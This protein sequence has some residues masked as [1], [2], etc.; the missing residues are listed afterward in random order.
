MAEPGAGRAELHLALVLLGVGDEFLE[1]L[2]RQ[3]LAH[4]QQDRN[5]GDERDRREIVDGAVERLLIQRLALGV[6]ADGPEHHGVAVG[7]GIG[8]ASGA[9]HAAGAA[10]VLDHDLLAENLAHARRHDAAEHVGRAA[11]RE[12]ND[13]RHRLGRIALSLSHARKAEQYAKGRA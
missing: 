3:V 1:I 8:H 7:R 9:G 2:H 10:D 4:G 13:H 5:L 11:G 6:G 12:R